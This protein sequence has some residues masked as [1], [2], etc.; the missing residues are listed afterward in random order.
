LTTAQLVSLTLFV[1]FYVPCIATV[2]AMGK[3]IGW[4]T[5]AWISAFTIV[6]AAVIGGLGRL[7]FTVF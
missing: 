5:T 7:A 1:V 2:A 4:K 6:V 3:E